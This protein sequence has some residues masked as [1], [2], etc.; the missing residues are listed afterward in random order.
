[1]ERKGFVSYAHDDRVEFR[2]FLKVIQA[3][4][5]AFTITFWY[6]KHIDAGQAW[7]E[8]IHAAIKAADICVM[9]CS[10]AWAASTYIT[11]QEIPAMRTR[12]GQGAVVV[13]VVLEGQEWKDFWSDRHAIPH[14]QGRLKPILDWPRHRDGYREVH[15]RVRDVLLKQVGVKL[16]T[17]IDPG[18]AA[19]LPQHPAGYRW[20]KDDQLIRIDLGGGPL[21]AEVAENPDT[22]RRLQAVVDQAAEVAE[23]LSAMESDSMPRD[24]PAHVSNLLALA[25]QGVGGIVAHLQELYDAAQHIAGDLYILRKT[26][27]D[28][29]NRP[30]LGGAPLARLE[31]LRDRAVFLLRQFPGAIAMD[32][33]VLPTAKALPLA[34]LA[35]QLLDST[36]DL[37]VIGAENWRDLRSW[38]DPARVVLDQDRARAVLSVRNMLYR[39]GVFAMDFAPDPVLPGDQEDAAMIA[40]VSDLLR[41]CE[42]IVTSFLDDSP[43]EVSAAFARLTAWAKGGRLRVRSLDVRRVSDRSRDDVMRAEPPDAFMDQVKAMILRGEVPPESWAPFITRLSI[44]EPRWWTREKARLDFG[45]LRLLSRF[46]ALTQLDV[47]GTQVSDVGPLSGLTALTSLWLGNTA[48][49]DVGPLSR[50]T[51]LTSLNLWITQVSDVAPLSELTALKLLW[52]GSTAVNDVGPLSGLTSLTSLVLSHTQVRDIGPLSGLTALTSLYLT[53]TQVSD[54]GPLSGL[55]SLTMLDLGDTRVSDVGPLSGLTA[56]TSLDLEGTQVSDVGPLSNLTTLESL[57]L[58][59][60]EV[61]DV[62]PLSK[63]TA[64]TLLDLRDTRVTDVRPLS[65]LTAL[66]SLDLERTQVSDVGPLSRMTALAALNLE[67]TQ[68]SDVGPL[69]RLTTLTSLTLAATTV[70]DLGPLAELVTLTELDIAATDVDDLGPLCGLTELISLNIVHTRVKDLNPLSRLT[71]LRKLYVS[72]SCNIDYSSLTHLIDLQIIDADD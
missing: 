4:Q 54:V 67:D 3:L 58:A 55:T 43:R 36:R 24:L 14:S 48:V 53:G 19:D 10:P 13:P 21:D 61:S 46:T 26:T 70:I 30:L 57:D 68:V 28:R 50:L 72:K 60:T 62:G 7:N 32:E 44:S 39:I 9:L 34:P 51:A 65:G 45:D 52:L 33:Q 5:N 71:N 23:E 41:G 18:K 12:L 15:Q 59:A 69:S 8:E 66:V 42:D 16:R 11:R 37:K 40:R 22:A 35:L 31:V 29:P 56:L 17:E 49:S 1:M 20:I 38:L 2:E 6:D 47:A 25:R 63:L 27:S 64:L